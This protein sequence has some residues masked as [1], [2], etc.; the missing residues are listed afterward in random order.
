MEIRLLRGEI[1]T[2]DA[3]DFDLVSHVKWRASRQKK[4]TYAVTGNPKQ[5]F[6]LMHR[7]VM[8]AQPGEEVDHINRNGLDNRREN[9]RLISHS[10]NLV[11]AAMFSHNTSGY[12]GV[13]KGIKG[14][15]ASAKYHYKRVNSRE[16]PDIQTAAFVRDA[17]I[18]Q[19]FGND[20]YLNFPNQLPSEEIVQEAK[21][22]IGKAGIA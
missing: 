1:A 5:G 2:V 14:W 22:L 19:L 11:N 21:R 18:R 8:N 13:H 15:R 7:L 16:Y 9:L 3:E 6:V 10:K 17:I 4:T 12:K 20:V